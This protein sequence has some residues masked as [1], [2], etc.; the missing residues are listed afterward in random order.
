MYPIKLHLNNIDIEN[1]TIICNRVEFKK[2]VNINKVVDNQVDLVVFILIH[3]YFL[4]DPKRI[5]G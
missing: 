1:V 5:R 3:F 4:V 2:C